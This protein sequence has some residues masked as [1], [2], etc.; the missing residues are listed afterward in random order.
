[1]RDEL[2][3]LIVEEADGKV[4]VQLFSDPTSAKESFD[5]LVGEPGQKPQRVR[6]L[7]VIDKTGQAEVWV[8]DLPIVVAE[9]DR[10]DH[11]IIGEKV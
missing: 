8:K 4:G 9:T 7:K 11:Y 2:G 6:F 5:N 1:M 10:K 3:V